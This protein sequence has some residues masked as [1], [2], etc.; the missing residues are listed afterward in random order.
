MQKL[1]ILIVTHYYRPEN[2][3]INYVADL[4]VEDGHHVEILTGKPNYPEG[5]FYKGYGFFSPLVEFIKDIRVIRLPIIP[6][7]KKFRYLG[8]IMNYLS[9]VL[10]ATLF[11]LIRYKKENYDVIFIYGTSPV[12][13]AIPA[14]FLSKLIKAPVMFW[15]QDLWP[16]SITSQGFS[17]PKIFL[18]FIRV[19]VNTIYKNSDLVVCQSKSFVETIQK[20]HSLKDIK[21]RYLPNVIDEIFLTKNESKGNLPNEIATLSES[22]NIIFTGNISEAQ[23]LDTVLDAAEILKSKLYDEIHFIIVGSGS[24]L[25]ELKQIRD[26]KNLSNVTFTGAYP[27]EDMPMIVKFS[28]ALLVSLKSEYIFSLTIPNKLQSYLAAGKPILGSLD[29]EGAR[30]IKENGCGLTAQSESASSLSEIAIQLFNLSEKK[31]QEMGENSITCFNSNFSKE[32][33]LNRFN[34]YLEELVIDYN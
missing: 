2:L 30:I 6:R 25:D 7:G 33:F 26:K 14:I 34:S 15:V 3:P 10:S 13:N 12:T 27:L 20:Q 18:N 19:I 31:K 28:D 21:L 5:K 16:E 29:G 17:M 24:K 23:S 32:I 8:L 9:F 4:L 22:F 11:S 1:K